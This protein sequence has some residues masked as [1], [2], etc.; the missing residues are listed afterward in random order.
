M[1][2]AR[3]KNKIKDTA[4]IVRPRENT[5]KAVL[6]FIAVALSLLSAMLYL[7]GQIH[8]SAYLSAWGLPGG[9]FPLSKEDSIIT[10]FFRF[11]LYSIKSASYALFIMLV[12]VSCLFAVFISC[13]KPV[14]SFLTGALFRLRDKVVPA[15]KRNVAIT[16]THDN[17]VDAIGGIT[18][19]IGSFV[20]V[21]VLLFLP[22]IWIG[23]EAK[24]S[25]NQERAKIISGF[26]EKEDFPLQLR[27]ILY[28]KNES[29]GFDQYSGH[30]INT[31]S[32]HCALYNKAKGVTIFPLTSV[33]RMVVNETRL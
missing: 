29:R 32:T 6:P 15:L 3:Y 21:P 10:G 16:P 13:Y 11:I 17:F 4:T 30:L 18:L 2:L 31:S 24:K 12:L 14:A 25:A 27:I 26:V 33:S 9:L 8:Y 22:C 1:R 28:V 7:Y 19:I 5:M 23:K 20:L